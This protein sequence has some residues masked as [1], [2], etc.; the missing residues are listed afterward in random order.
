MSENINKKLRVALIHD[1]FWDYGGAER[2]V[3][4]FHNMFPDAP[5]YTAFVHRASLG[6]HWDRFKDWDIRTTWAQQIPCIHKIFSPLVLSFAETLRIPLESISKVTSICGIPRGAGGIPSRI[7]RP[8]D[9]L[10]DAISRSP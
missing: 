9:L 2:V 10:S 6:I 5:I 8:R 1:Y 7:N 3:E 4:E